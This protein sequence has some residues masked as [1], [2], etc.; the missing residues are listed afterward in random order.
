MSKFIVMGVTVTVIEL[1]LGLWQSL[2][3]DFVVALC[4]FVFGI[5]SVALILLVHRSSPR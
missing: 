3:R 4:C 1:A 5:I 2:Q